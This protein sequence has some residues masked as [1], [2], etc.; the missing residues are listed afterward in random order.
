MD[1]YRICQTV[2]PYPVLEYPCNGKFI[3]IAAPVLNLA[4]EYDEPFWHQN[5]EY[6]IK[7][8]KILEEEG[9]N[10]LRYRGYVPTKDELLQNVKI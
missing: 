7:R 6:E 3:D 1:L 10:F 8:Q 9:W 2:F 5:E 4:I